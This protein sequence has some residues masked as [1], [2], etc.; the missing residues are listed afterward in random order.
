MKFPWKNILL[1][2]TLTQVILI[3]W[4]LSGTYIIPF[5]LMFIVSIVMFFSSQFLKKPECCF[6]TTVGYIFV[7]II[8]IGLIQYFNPYSIKVYE[9]QFSFLR[10]IDNIKWVPTSIFDY[11]ITG[12]ALSSL[13]EISTAFCSFLGS[14]VLFQSKK[15]CN[16]VIG[17]FATNAT[18]MGIYGIIQKMSTSSKLIYG[19]VSTN[20]DI[21]SS[22]P[23]STA[24]GVFLNF[25]LTASI[26]L[27]FISLKRNKNN[28]IIKFLYWL[29]CAIMCAYAAYDTGS[30]AVIIFMGVSIILSFIIIFINLFRKYYFSLPQS[31][32]ISAILITIIILV[33][34]CIIYPYVLEKDVSNLKKTFLEGSVY[35]RLQ[36]YQL[37]KETIL[38]RPLWG[39]GGNSCEHILSTKMIQNQNKSL[40][41]KYGASTKNAHND[42]LQYTLEYGLIGFSSICALIILWIITFLKLKTSP[43]NI[44]LFMGAFLCLLHSCIDMPF[45]IPSTTIAFS[46]FVAASISP[47]KQKYLQNEKCI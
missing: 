18:L 26:A 24:A 47:R 14:I 6:Y 38:E 29:F 44:I 12:N 46:L 37:S 21:Y 43:F 16:I 40:I 35:P 31:L 3:S 28:R 19:I 45:Q 7:I 11:L 36:M 34:S 1:A 10:N 23:L 8:L 42:L 15:S 4:G 33:S 32:G 20:S 30:I 22:F 13:S 9:E 41:K 27:A 17:F 2:S 5:F 39:Y 25:G